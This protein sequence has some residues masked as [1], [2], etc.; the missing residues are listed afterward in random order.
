MTV[1]SPTFPITVAAPLHHFH[2]VDL[3]AQKALPT[4]DLGALRGP[5]GLAFAAGKVWF[6][7][8]A[9]KAIG[10]YDPANDKTES[11]ELPVPIGQDRTHMIYVFP[12]LNPIVTSNVN[13][14]TISVIEKTSSSGGPPP[15]P[16]APRPFAPARPIGPKRSFPLAGAQKASMFL[17][18]E[19]KSGSL[20]PGD[21]TMVSRSISPP[22]K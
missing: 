3:L 21:G 5:H 10:S 7:A 14:A 9:A 20:T 13:S 12:S 19:K 8:E 1:N 22:K 15:P 6:T 2:P 11:T 18:T 17:P 4:I 16:G